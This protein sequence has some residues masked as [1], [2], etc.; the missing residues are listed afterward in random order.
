MSNYYYIVHIYLPSRDTTCRLRSSMP[1]Q[2]TSSD[3]PS[4]VMTP[5]TAL[6]L[7]IVN[8]VEFYW[9]RNSEFPPLKKFIDKYGK[10]FSLQKLVDKEAF[11]TAM[12]NRG[13]DLPFGAETPE[14]LTKEQMAAILLVTN[15][16]DKR[17]QAAKLK[18]ID[19]S[20]TK[21]NGWLKNPGFKEYLHHIS[22]SNFTDALHVAQEGLMKRVEAGDVNA[23]KFYMEATGRYSGES[24][25]LEN[26]KI[27][28]AKLGEILQ[29]HIKDPELLRAIA[30]D[31]QSIMAGQPLP[32]PAVQ[33]QNVI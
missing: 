20:T 7:D 31:F 16:L 30:T 23:I 8:W 4:R 6:E 18:S 24:G 3:V 14:E 33:I 29:I 27:V 15:Y 32:S 25:Q 5:L 13:I 28:L 21:W 22:S 11:R 26:I 9:H 12:K 2:T 17:S 10:D 19:V 1:G